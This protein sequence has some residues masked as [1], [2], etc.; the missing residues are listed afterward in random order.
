MNEKITLIESYIARCDKVI[1][2]NDINQAKNLFLE[3]Q[4]LFE[5]DIPHFFNGLDSEAGRAY[6]TWVSFNQYWLTDM[7][8][9]KAKLEKYKATLQSQNVSVPTYSITNNNYAFAQNQTSIS[10]KATIKTAQY[11]VSEMSS[12]SDT[13]TKEA[14]AKLDE[15]LAIAKSKESRK[16]KWAK[17]G[18]FFKWIAEK[19]VDLAVA[20]A[21]ALLQIIQSLG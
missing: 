9:I 18:A 11:T 14:L 7:P 19:S 1:A 20:F 6:P 4:S 15:L 17:L 5:T 16:S 8:R 3:I 2:S 12:L 21:P 13:D 10:I